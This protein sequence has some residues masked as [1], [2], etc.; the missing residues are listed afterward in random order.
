M[1]GNRRKKRQ[2]TEDGATE[3]TVE[4]IAPAL[5]PRSPFDEPPIGVS[6]VIADNA[7]NESIDVSAVEPAFVHA[8]H[9]LPVP[10]IVIDLDRFLAGLIEICERLD[11]KMAASCSVPPWDYSA[12]GATMLGERDTIRPLAA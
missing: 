10:E 11:A 2:A 4:F 9:D 7:G 6:A 1:F 8:A 3:T 12:T 5:S